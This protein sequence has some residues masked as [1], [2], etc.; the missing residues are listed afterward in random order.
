LAPYPRARAVLGDGFDELSRLLPPPEKRGLVLV[1]PPY[2]EEDEF[3]RL[4]R[5]FD[6]AY[7]RFATGIYMIWLPLKSRHDADALAGEMLNSGASKLLLLLLDVGRSRDAP[8]ERLSACGLLVVNPP[9]GF[10][11]A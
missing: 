10:S 7:A 6:S 3:E 2:E 9:Y 5:A 4:S 1:D 8:P 11:D